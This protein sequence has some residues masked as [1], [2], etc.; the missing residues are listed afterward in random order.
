MI[1]MP[2]LALIPY[3]P[4][5]TFFTVQWLSLLSPSW[6]YMHLDWSIGA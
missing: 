1:D 5:G 6:M 3:V 2:D 4:D